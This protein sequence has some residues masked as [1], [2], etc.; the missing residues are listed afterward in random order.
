[1]EGYVKPK[2]VS[3]PQAVYNLFP[4]IHSASP[5]DPRPVFECGFFY[6]HEIVI[7]ID[8]SRLLLKNYSYTLPKGRIRKYTSVCSSCRTRVVQR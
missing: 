5:S 6:V 3:F 7:Q 8:W 2:I 4:Q 1:M